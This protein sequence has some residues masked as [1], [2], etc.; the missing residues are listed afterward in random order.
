MLYHIVQAF[1]LTH[2]CQ[3]KM[4]KV[5]AAAEVLQNVVFRSATL[6]FKHSLVHVNRQLQALTLTNL[7]LDY[8]DV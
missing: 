1:L 5:P 4:P 8:L 3:K 7:D 2:I 6:H